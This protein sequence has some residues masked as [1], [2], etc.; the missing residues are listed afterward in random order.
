MAIKHVSLSSM[1]RDSMGN[2]FTTHASIVAVCS[3]DRFKKLFDRDLTDKKRKYPTIY[4]DRVHSE[5][6]LN[7]SVLYSL[8][9]QWNLQPIYKKHEW[10]LVIRHNMQQPG[11]LFFNHRLRTF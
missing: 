8:D 10:F 3:L 5:P 7:H 9:M 4:T 1:P 2:C 6:Q 11:S